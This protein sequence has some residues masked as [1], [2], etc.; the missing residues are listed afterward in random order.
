MSNVAGQGGDFLVVAGP[1][2][3]IAEE[4]AISA[5]TRAA[6]AGLLRREP[7]P[8]AFK[9]IAPQLGSAHPSGT[10]ASVAVQTSEAGANSS[11]DPTTNQASS[12][13]VTISGQVDVSRQ[14]LDMSLPGI[15]T[16]VSA[17]LGKAL[18]AALENEVLNGPGS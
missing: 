10:G 16:V 6:V 15:D 1:P 9:V 17:E 7:I 4:F 18:G 14:L 12:D 3:F 13:I 2:A 8:Q 5:R 11:T